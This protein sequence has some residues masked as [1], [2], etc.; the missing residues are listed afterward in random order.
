MKDQPPLSDAQRECD[1]RYDAQEGH[2]TTPTEYDYSKAL[3]FEDCDSI[4]HTYQCTELFPDFGESGPH[5]LGDA[6][7]TANEG[8]PG[9]CN[10]PNIGTGSEPE[11]RQQPGSSLV[12]ENEASF[13][14]GTEKHTEGAASHAQ[15]LS[16]GTVGAVPRYNYSHAPNFTFDGSRSPSLPLSQFT[17]NTMDSAA[18]DVKGA[19]PTMFAPFE[20]KFPDS[21]SAKEFRKIQTRGKRLPYR[22]PASDSTITEI[23]NNRPYHVE[24]IYNAMTR[25]DKARDNERSI[26]MKRWVHGAYYKSHLVEAHCHKVSSQSER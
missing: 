15:T 11:L 10:F 21:Q 7:P 4:S 19:A 8:G 18:Q 22:P 23:E 5:D 12:I 9:H 24:R 16:R 1:G 14:R 13:I 25:G 2:Y 20:G 3:R 17:G 6:A 26:A